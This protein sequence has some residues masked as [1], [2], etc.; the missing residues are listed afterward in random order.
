MKEKNIH[1][2]LKAGSSFSRKEKG[3]LLPFLSR[4]RFWGILWGVV[5][6]GFLVRLTVS[7]Q[8]KS[9]DPAVTAPPAI[10]DMATYVKLAEDILKGILPPTFYYQPFYYS[11]FLPMA[12][13]F[14][15]EIG[16][17]L[18]QSL[19]GAGIIFLAGK[20]TLYVTGSRYGGLAGAFLCAFSAILIYFTPY[21]LLELLQ[22]FLIILTF[23][24]FFTALRRHSLK[25]YFF[26]GLVWGASILTRGN[27]LLFLPLFFL[28]L[29][30]REGGNI[31]V[32]FKKKRFY[33]S[34][35]LLLGGMF[36]IQ[37]PYTGYNSW[38]LK[39]LSGP[40][41]AGPS[42]L[43]LGNNRE[44]APAGLEVPYPP[45]FHVLMR[46]EKAPGGVV[47]GILDWAKEEPLAF[48]EH[49][50]KQF[51]LF[52]DGRDYPNNISQEYNAVKS[53][54][55]AKLHF[56]PTS[57]LLLLALAGFFQAVREKTLF[58]RKGVLLLWGM[59]LIY[60]FSVALFYILARFRL[61]ALPLLAMAGGGFLASLFR[62]GEKK[63]L[64]RQGLYLAGGIFFVFLFYP[65]Y[66]FTY[67]P[68]LMQSCRPYG[69][70]NQVF[71]RD[72][73]GLE[74]LSSQEKEKPYE[75]L[76][77]SS[78]IVQG[79]YRELPLKEGMQIIKIFHISPKAPL[80]PGNTGILVI[81][82]SS[83]GPSALVVEHPGGRL[84]FQPAKALDYLVIKDIPFTRESPGEGKGEKITV[85][86]HISSLSGELS[87]FP[88]SARDYG[89]SLLLSPGETAPRKT[90]MEFVMRLLIPHKGN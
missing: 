18:F 46:K 78:S 36:L 50:I 17:I 57:L 90:G 84:F 9:Y 2:S 71:S 33:F 20:N 22:A 24:L 4:K 59:I 79:S 85:K 64:F 40:S 14:G 39:K 12:R 38:K 66:I 49:K 54:L 83:S 73:P 76:L 8:L 61:P 10:S 65:L 28:F 35:L 68:L 72:V 70:R 60:A 89:R 42:V 88:D 82:L 44:S 48:L 45:S 37:L 29:L 25:Y 5:F 81:P 51:F 16:L 13:F 87:L 43:A 19:L 31:K 69:V 58:R 21:A 7:F 11:I 26:A 56:L 30:F 32:F 52:W 63:E 41:T 55:M 23:D 75:M 27:T 77:D 53:P 15:G 86:F 6:I 62:R 67:E 3:E 80:P 34:L 74:K 1:H 47:G